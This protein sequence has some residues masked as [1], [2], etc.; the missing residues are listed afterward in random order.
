MK[1][2]KGRRQQAGVIQLGGIGIVLTLVFVFY[3]AIGQKGEERMNRI[4]S[5]F[6]VIAN[7]VTSFT[8]LLWDGS[9]VGTKEV[10]DNITYGCKYTVWRMVYETDWQ[11]YPDQLTREGKPIPYNPYASGDKKKP[12]KGSKKVSGGKTDPVKPAKP[13]INVKGAVDDL[14]SLPDVPFIGD[15]KEPCE[16]DCEEEGVHS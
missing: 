8:A 7:F 4:C 13:A 16:A 11:D 2:F 1:D 12:E 9:E 15:D 5:P 6:S 3:C 10:F 14:P